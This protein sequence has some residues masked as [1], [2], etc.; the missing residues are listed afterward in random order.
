MGDRYRFIEEKNEKE[1]KKVG[2][3]ISAC[4]VESTIVIVD[5][6]KKKII[7][8]TKRGKNL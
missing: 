2:I 6:K 4:K 1:K 8:K 7:G 5:Y 3:I